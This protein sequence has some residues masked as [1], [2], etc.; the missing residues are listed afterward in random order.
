MPLIDEDVARLR[1][2]VDELEEAGIDRLPPE[3]RLAETLRV[4]RSRL[5]TMLKRLE[6]DGTIWRH[7]GKG[8]FVGRRLASAGGDLSGAIGAGD[9]FEARAL[10]EPMLAAQ[11]AIHATPAD[12]TGLQ[13]HVAAMAD[14]PSFHQWKR[15]DDR[16]HHAVAVACHNPMLLL[17]YEVLRA[18][19]RARIDARLQ[20]V[21]G[22]QPP[23]A[24]IAAEHRSFVAAI[25]AH[26]PVAAAQAMRAHIHSV[27]GRLFGGG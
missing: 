16:L 1:R 20:A 17:L 25:A 21:F 4:T 10:L 9:I 7:V 11:A 27:R 13:N 23:R 26:D 8:T 14:M 18:E 5:R 24:I 15:L 6:A 12:V 3:P 22:E 2:L 19:A